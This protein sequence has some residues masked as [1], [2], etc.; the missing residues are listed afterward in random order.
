VEIVKVFPGE[1][2]GGPGFVKAVRGPRPWT[3]IMP[4]GGVTPDEDNLRAWFSAGVACVG[5]GSNLVRKAWIDAGDYAAIE[6]LTRVTL[7]LIRTIRS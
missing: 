7:E 2:V 1:S 3:R 5:M 6:K 4:T